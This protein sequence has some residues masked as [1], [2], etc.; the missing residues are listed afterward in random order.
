[1]RFLTKSRFTTAITCP[2]KLAY[3]DDPTFANA[4]SQNEFLKALAD[5]GHQVGALA[6]CLF[7]EGIEIDA[8]G[9]D[10]QV[11]QT[12]SLLRRDEVVLFEAAIRFDRLFIRADLLRKL[13]TTIELYEVKA[14]GF[15]SLEGEAQIIGKRG[16]ITSEFRP[17]IYDVAFQRHVLLLA[18]PNFKIKTFLVMPDQAK[19]CPEDALAQRLRIQRLDTRRIRIDVDPSLRDGRLA[20]QILNVLPV[21]Q[22]VDLVMKSPLEAGGRS[23]EFS[24]AIAELA[25]SLDG[26]ALSPRSGSHCKAC[27]FRASVSDTQQGLRDG[28][29]V[30]WSGQFRLNPD[31]ISQG[32]V[33][34]LYNFRGAESVVANGKLLLPDLESEDVKFKKENSKISNSHRQWLQCEESR[35]EVDRP[36]VLSDELAAKL[37]NLNYP[38]H[39][40]DFET[41]TPALP[42]HKGRRPYELLL[43]Q[44]SHHRV[45]RSGQIA[46]TTQYLDSRPGAFPNFDTVRS[47]AHALNAD[48]GSVIHWWTHERTVLKQVREQLSTTAETVPDR[49]QL[50]S[51]INS[52]VGD[53]NSPGRLVD[54]GQHLVAP[55][56]FFPGTKGSSSIKKVLPAILRSSPALRAKYQA[57]I[58]GSAG[59]M[60]SLNFLDQSWVRLDNSGQVIDPYLLLSGRFNDPDLDAIDSVGEENTV[61][62]DGGAAMVAYGLLQGNLLDA[63]GRALLEQQLYRYCE[64]DTLAM[65]MTWEGLLEQTNIVHR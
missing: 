63:A 62:A 56:A 49:D 20:R 41:A 26:S 61:V 1:M 34:D 30:C 52:L 11:A 8:V 28:R 32:T 21:D 65:V 4:N 19:P 12:N 10:A 48:N 27:E 6:K 36:F 9:H 60:K 59:G 57:P 18:F 54:L 15:D 14:K 39:F 47:L 37:T 23:W 64:L 51:F 13:G 31:T 5:G 17:Y 22:Y 40:I 35:G 2:T 16:N 42:F 7:P 3:L 29:V 45:E 44:Y 55:L 53:D 50:I 46:H 25:K 38:L 43:F 33:F 58:Y 24:E